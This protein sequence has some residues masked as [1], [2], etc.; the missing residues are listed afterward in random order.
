MVAARSPGDP[1]KGIRRTIR[2]GEGPPGGGGH[3]ARPPPGSAFT[4][5]ARDDALNGPCPAVGRMDPQRSGKHDL[6]GPS[7]RDRARRVRPRPSPK[8]G[9]VRAGER[10]TLVAYGGI[11]RQGADDTCPV[12]GCLDLGKRHISSSRKH[13]SDVRLWAVEPAMCEGPA[14]RR[15]RRRSVVGSLSLVAWRRPAAG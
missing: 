15:L 8:D 4:G 7:G 5:Q 10:R 11:I 12:P 13:L 9:L 14:V 6:H 2:P 1:L 3:P